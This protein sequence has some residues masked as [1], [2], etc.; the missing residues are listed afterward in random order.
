MTTRAV[1]RGVARARDRG[2]TIVGAWLGLDV[3]PTPLAEAGFTRGW[4]PWWMTVDLSA[5]IG[6]S[7][8][9]G[10]NPPARARSAPLLA[11]GRAGR[12]L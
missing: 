1:L 2:L 9:P 7:P 5:M 4:S 10:G 6:C 8:L 12:Q 3:D 11:G